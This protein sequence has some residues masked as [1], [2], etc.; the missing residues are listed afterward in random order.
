TCPYKPTCPYQPTCPYKPTCP[1][2]PTCPF[3][4]TYPYK[5]TCA[6]KPTCPYKPTSP[7]KPT[8]LQIPVTS[9]PRHNSSLHGDGITI[10]RE[11]RGGEK[12]ESVITSTLP[13][14][15]VNLRQALH[16]FNAI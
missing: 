13:N 15:H 12:R 5:P 9:S 7:Y 2:Q 6:Y 3:K 16:Y 4:P 8:C 11:G 10:G 1:Y 14:S